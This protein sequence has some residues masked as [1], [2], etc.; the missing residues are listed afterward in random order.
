MLL[1]TFSVS[2]VQFYYLRMFFS[3][4]IEKQTICSY[5][6]LNGYGGK[7]REIYNIKIVYVEQRTTYDTRQEVVITVYL[8]YL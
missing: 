4:F 2:V 6:K 1:I 5:C 3:F 7:D 8:V